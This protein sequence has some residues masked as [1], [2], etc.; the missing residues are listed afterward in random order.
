LT[1]GGLF[2]V[3]KSMKDLF[4]RQRQCP[5]DM[6]AD[7]KGKLVNVDLVR[8]VRP[9]P[10]H[11]MMVVW[12]EDTVV[13]HLEWGVEPRRAGTLQNHLP[14]LRVRRRDRPR[15]GAA[16]NPEIDCFFGDR[17]RRLQ[18]QATNAEGAKQP[19][20]RHVMT[21]KVAMLHL[22]TPLFESSQNT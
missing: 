11:I 16:G 21:C 4:G 9:M 1:Y 15:S 10:A 3:R 6:P 19:P 12:C 7:R 22:D 20:P 8:K 14:L 17:S 2:D 13:K 5:I 18:G